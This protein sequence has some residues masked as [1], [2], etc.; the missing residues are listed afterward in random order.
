MDVESRKVVVPA[1]HKLLCG[2]SMDDLL[3]F[4]HALHLRFT[5]STTDKGMYSCRLYK[6]VNNA[7]EIE[8]IEEVKAG[9]KSP[10]AALI[11][12]MS[13]FLSASDADY[14]SYQRIRW[15]GYGPQEEQK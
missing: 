15:A 7:G 8:T 3:I 13:D 1:L 11:N 14:H 12:A 6:Q 4:I 10:Q 2:V 9:G 5:L